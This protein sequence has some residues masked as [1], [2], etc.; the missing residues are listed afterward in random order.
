MTAN[1]GCLNI[2]GTH[3][4]ANVGCLNIHG[5]HVTANVGCL[6]IHG[7]HVT[8][9]NFTNIVFFSVSDLK[10]VYY[11]NYLSSITMPWTRAEK[12]LASLLI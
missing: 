3:V 8:A 1:V 7:V 4:T 6:N 5:V 11:N 12:Y 10:I 9:N 2:H